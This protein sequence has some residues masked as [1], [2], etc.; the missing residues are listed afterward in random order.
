MVK[1]FKINFYENHKT[2]NFLKFLKDFFCVI[3]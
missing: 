2:D 1:F 3:D